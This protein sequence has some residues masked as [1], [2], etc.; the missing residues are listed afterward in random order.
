[1]MVHQKT[2]L[3]VILKLH[4]GIGAHLAGSVATLLL[5]LPTIPSLAS[6][7]E[8]ADSSPWDKGQR[9]AVRLIAASAMDGGS[10]PVLRAGVEIRLHKGWKTYWRYPGDSGVPPRFSFARSENVGNVTVKWPSPLRFS[11]E[12]GQSIG[13]KE[14]VIFPLAVQAAD[15][16]KP[17]ILRLDLDYAICE[18]LCM[19][20]EAKAEVD[21]TSGRT[22]HDP[23]LAVAE[24]RVPK[25]SGVGGGM[26]FSIAAVR[27][28][29]P[30]RVT[31]DVTAPGIA[32]I[33]LF[34]EGPTP[35]WALPLPEPMVGAPPGTRRFSFALDGL[36]PGARAAGAVL[37]LTAVTPQ[38]AIEATYRLD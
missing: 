7:C 16:A 30:G 12:S 33:D 13:Y 29:M 21:L 8:A 5:L 27:Q 17:V 32:E 19:P 37:T 34:A 1:M 11:D 20:A 22:A 10:N 26:G 2:A 25:R 3:R 24:G 4:A 14:H 9:S 28:D 18:K 6:R 31:V 35:E 36:P 38:A 23:A 15:P